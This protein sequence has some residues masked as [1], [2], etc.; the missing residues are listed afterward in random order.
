MLA[1]MTERSHGRGT[2]R[3]K[4]EKTHYIS[5]MDLLCSIRIQRLLFDDSGKLNVEKWN[6]GGSRELTKLEHI[7]FS[8][9]KDPD[10]G[11]DYRFQVYIK[12]DGK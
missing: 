12:K 6:S 10:G 2:E 5:G 11:Q 3:K 9:D 1:Y 8:H 7:S 4:I